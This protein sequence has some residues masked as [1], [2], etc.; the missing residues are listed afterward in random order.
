MGREVM[1]S[2]HAG[3]S[4]GGPLRDGARRLLRLPRCRRPRRTRAGPELGLHDG[5]GDG[6]WAGG[7]VGGVKMYKV[8][9]RHAGINTFPGAIY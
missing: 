3:F 2:I 1:E 7:A 8:A 5:V 6:L 4:A 9:G